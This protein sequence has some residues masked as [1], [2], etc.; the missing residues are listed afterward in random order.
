MQEIPHILGFTAGE[1]TPWLSTR[2]D[3]Q[4]YQRGASRISNFI[5]Q[6]YGGV[7]RR[8][9]TAF[10]AEAGSGTEDAVKLFPFTYSE[11]DALMLEFYPG[12]MRVYRDGKPL[13]VR[14][15]GEGDGVQPEE[16]GEEKMAMVLAESPSAATAAMDAAPVATNET[17]ET[18]PLRD[19]DANLPLRPPPVAG[20]VLD[21]PY[22]LEV[23][24]QTA[25]QIRS[26]RVTQVNDA[27]YVT[28]PTYPPVVLYRLADKKWKCEVVDFDTYPRATYTRQDDEMTVKLMPLSDTVVLRLPEDGNT[29][30]TPEMAGR[31]YVLLDADVPEETAYRNL[32]FS[33][34]P[35][36]LGA[37]QTSSCRRSGVYYRKD[38]VT[39]FYRFW[40]CI[41]SY[42][43]DDYA[44]SDNPADY[45]THFM[46]GAFW[47]P[48]WNGVTEVC[49]DWELRTNGT[50][51]AQLELWRTYDHPNPADVL[52]TIP[53]GR[54]Y[55]FLDA[56]QDWDWTCVKS[57]GQSSYSERQNW[58]LSGSEP[59][60]CRMCVVVREADATTFTKM[61]FF[62]KF[63][64]SREY[65]FLITEVTD[66]HTATAKV[67]TCYADFPQE[68]RSRKWSFG[69]FGEYNGYPAFSSYSGGRLWFGGMRRSPTTLIGS[70]TDDFHN[71]RVSSEDDSALH[72]TIASDNQSRICWIAPARG[73]LV[74]TSDGVWML[75]SG[76]GAPLSPSNAAF[77]RQTSVGCENLPALAVEGCVIFPQRCGTRLREISYKLESDGFS[78]S[79]LSLLAEHLLR[80]GV[81]EYAVQ[82]GL[83]SY[84]WVVLNDGTLAVL[85]LHP[86]QQVSAWQRVEIPGCKV[87]HVATLP[88]AGA[89]LDEV[90]LVLRRG[91]EGALSLQRICPENLYL[92]E[93]VRTTADS[94]GEVTSLRCFAGLDVVLVREGAEPETRRVSADGVLLGLIP[95]A[96]YRIGLPF[97]SLLQ[98]LPL[99]SINSFNS[100]R[101]L[102]RLRLRLLESSL[103]AE[104]KA[105]HAEHWE[106]LEPDRLHLAEPYTG[107]VRL[108]HMPE[109][110]VGQGLCLRSTGLADFRLLGL[111]AEVDYHGK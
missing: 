94:V 31:E 103:S 16:N 23:P 2:Y 68:L 56:A 45:P 82:E 39:S 30:F 53:A 57:F 91:E 52:P 10:V 22:E 20:G 61:M 59:R 98:T 64:G 70:V 83:G 27:V 32:G 50:W 72:L 51:N 15:G 75:G 4:A 18:P 78:A 33:C 76:D 26:L 19:T 35:T 77:R 65:K 37:L 63:R 96:T 24:W 58:A 21:V 93:V 102:S 62:R 7:K 97:I 92:D 66:A 109:A 43:P 44:D 34:G 41:R 42:T 46:A 90:W 81:R 84:V 107:S 3:L 8:H 60:P 89:E 99:E 69:A 5:V 100:V 87:L 67:L 17:V 1:L 48:D 101:E 106:R 80:S 49:G 36:L 74:G 110:A 40:T 25:A 79:D 6:P 108:S 14:K 13:T 47:R 88:R 54:Y 12:R 71:F 104:Y 9:G 55:Y 95:N 11:T 85:T 105:T 28:C 73:L 29:L 86:E 111:T 38:S